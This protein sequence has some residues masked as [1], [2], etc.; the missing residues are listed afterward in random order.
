MVK[1]YKMHGTMQICVHLVES[2]KL[3]IVSRL[4]KGRAEMCSAATA[5]CEPTYISTKLS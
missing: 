2:M 3:S 4:N 1:F 5:V